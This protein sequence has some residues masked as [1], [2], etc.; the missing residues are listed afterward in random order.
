MDAVTD[1]AVRE[2]W[3]MKSAQTGYTEII[4]NIVGYYVHQDPSPIMVVQ[5][6]MDAAEDWSRDRLAPMIRDTPV[7]AERFSKEKRRDAANTLRHKTFPGGLL[8]LAISN[9]PSSLASKPIRV[10]IFDEVDK[11]PTSARHA[12]DPVKLGSKRTTTFW[13]RKI[14]AGSTPTV[15]G[16]SRIE[17]GFDLS[18]QRF[19]FVPCTHCGEFQRLVWANVRW[20][21]GRPDEAVYVCQHCGVELTDADKAGMLERGQWRSTK[22]TNGVAGFHISEL[23]SP[24]SSWPQMARAFLE[25]KRLPETLQQFIIEALGETWEDAG[26]KLEPQGLLS[27]RESYT[28]DSLPPGVMLLTAGTDVQDDRLETTIWGWGADEEAWRVEHIVLRGDPGGSALWKEHDELLR[29]RWRTDDGR[30]L[31][32]EACAVD[33]GGHYTEQVYLYCSKRTRQRVWAVKGVGGSGRLAWPRKASKAKRGY[34]YPVGV[35]TAKDTIYGRLKRVIEPGAG[36]VHLDATTDEAWLEQLTSETVV[37]RI[38]QGRKVRVW[39]PRQ[40]GIR[41]EALDCTVYAWCALQG[42]GGAELLRKR[43][44]HPMSA[45]VAPQSV[46]AEPPAETKQAPPAPRPAAPR[47]SWMGNRK[48]SWFRR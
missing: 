28:A 26:E 13:N 19:Y 18:D 36:Y 40:T 34:V 31:V 38:T 1:P 33:S 39:R 6:T 46:P 15:K 17:V 29:R 35:D 27:R 7:L 2:L 25:A 8:A 22:P 10:A 43:S 44:A 3:I 12:G 21:D 48:G 4:G 32:I 30:E 45:P 5:P 11:Y 47:P 14:I 42:R 23:Y 16:S 9:S 37:H 24:W 41:Q 20:P